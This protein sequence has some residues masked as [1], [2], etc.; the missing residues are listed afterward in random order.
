MSE[1]RP[2]L[3][4]V[5]NAALAAGVRD[6][7]T[8]IPA[9][10]VKWDADQG[11][12][13]CQILI[14]HVSSDEEGARVVESWPVVTGVPV[15]FPGANGFRITF[16]VADGD[17]GMLQFAHASLD[18]WLATQTPTRE[19]DPELDHDHALNDAVF[20]PGLKPFSAT[21]T[22]PDSGMSIGSETESQS[23]IAIT[24]DR[25]SVNGHMNGAAPAAREGDET[26]GHS[27]GPGAY[28]AG[29]YPVLGASASATDTIAPT[30]ST[31]DM[32]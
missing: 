4:N 2:S 16:A 24:S 22:I 32:G 19:V 5:I 12:A 10:V 31:V 8:L 27:H 30:G 20:L 17:T 3:Q 14:K 21:W 25:I 29:P 18:K 1:R 26:S 6:V 9:K 7:Y 11:R 23:R 13:D 15:I 28:Q